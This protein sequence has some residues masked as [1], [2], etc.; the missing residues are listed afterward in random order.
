MNEFFF[1]EFPCLLYERLK[2]NTSTNTAL[3]PLELVVWDQSTVDR[4]KEL[5]NKCT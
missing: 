5:D 1:I 3:R 4:L 2:R